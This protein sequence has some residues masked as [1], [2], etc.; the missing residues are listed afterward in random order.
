MRRDRYR[1]VRSNQRGVR[2]Q[3][4]SHVGVPMSSSGAAMIENDGVLHHVH[5]EEVALAEVVDRPVGG[6]PQR[7][8]TR[9]E[10]ATWKRVTTGVPVGARR[11]PSRAIAHA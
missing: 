6:D 5:R 4:A 1:T 2:S 8:Q 9:R 3:R 10:V 11:G 7:E